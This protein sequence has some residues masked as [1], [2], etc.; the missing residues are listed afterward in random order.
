MYYL[1]KITDNASLVAAIEE[2]IRYYNTGRYQIKLSSMTPMSTMKRM[3]RDRSAGAAANTFW[4][5]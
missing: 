2:Y 3:M 4:G 5:G 1:H